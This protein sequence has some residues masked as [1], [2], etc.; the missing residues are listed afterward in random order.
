MTTKRIIM[1]VTSGALTAACAIAISAPTWIGA[2]ASP[3]PSEVRLHLGSDSQQFSYGAPP[4]ATV[5]SLVPKKCALD[6]NSGTLIQLAGSPSGALPGLVD[7]GL[8]VKNPVNGPTG[9]PCGQVEA[10]NEVL[11]VKLGTQIAGRSFTSLHLD[12]EVT[13]NATV[14]LTLLGG[15]PG[16][17][18]TDYTM[19]TGP[20]VGNDREV[21]RTIPYVVDSSATDNTDGCA[22]ASSSGPNSGPND[23]CEWN[24]NPGFNFTS[25][26]IKAT[27]GTVALEGGNDFGPGTAMDTVL[28]LGNGAPHAV[29]DTANVD[30]NRSEPDTNNFVD[31]PVLANDTDPENDTLSVLSGSVSDPPHGTAVIQGT[32]IRYTPDDNYVG[33]D[34]FTYQATDGTTPS[35][36][37]TVSVDVVQVMCSLDTVSTPPQPSGVSG[38]F[39]RLTD[40]EQCKRYTLQV[41]ATDSGPAV[42]FAPQGGADVDYRG[43][44][45]FGPK[46]E[47]A[48]TLNLLL[49]Y[50]PELDNTYKNV[51][52]CDAPM[53]FDANGVVTEAHVPAGDTWCIASETT[54]G[55]GTGTIET[56]W[57]VWGHDDPNFK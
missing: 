20:V 48:G 16:Q 39:T 2:S 6:A 28:Y 31:I 32:G 38:S 26:T 24:I 5:Q 21:D 34:S 56:T 7:L 57:Q 14:V 13:K 33:P 36:A 44:I 4:N 8:G 54:V 41:N 35:A 9:T 23:N 52:W 18:P 53:V 1:W 10:P 51:P 27:V 30:Q 42:Q 55:Q 25:F 43:S 29:D 47:P 3:A 15:S 50:D 17:K 22:A 19:L 12:L 37:A 11:T 49:Q 40:P 45:T 46:P